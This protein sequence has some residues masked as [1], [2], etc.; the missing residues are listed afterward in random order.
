V[1]SGANIGAGCITCNYDGIAKHQTTIGDQAFI[2]SNVSL[3]APLQIGAQ[4]VVGAGSTI[5]KS[6]PDS[7]L[8]VARAKQKHLERKPPKQEKNNGS[9][10]QTGTKNT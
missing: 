10:G 9:T 8:A 5:T 4:A 3:V 2:G 1:G 7:F 6:V